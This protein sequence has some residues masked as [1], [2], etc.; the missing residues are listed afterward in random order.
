MCIFKRTIFTVCYHSQWSSQPFRLCKHQE[1][2]NAG[3]TPEPC[4]QARGH[5]LATVK[6][7]KKCPQCE[8]AH[9]TVDEKLQKAKDIITESKKTLVRADERCRALL[10]D[11]GIDASGAKD[12]DEVEMEGLKEEIEALDDEWPRNYTAGEFLK[13]RKKA[14]K[15]SLF[16]G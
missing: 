3:Q 15:A 16:M 4:K 10:G 13:N 12:E 1:S 6:V 7:Q 8:G 11:A 14:E 2:H 9:Q 5:P